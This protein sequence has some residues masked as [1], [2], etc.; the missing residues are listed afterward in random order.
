MD[1]LKY[2]FDKQLSWNFSLTAFIICRL[3][4][5]ITYFGK[6]YD[7][8][9]IFMGLQRPLALKCSRATYTGNKIKP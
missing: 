8:L 5:I 9:F 3:L 7:L 4:Q 1:F 2:L 6:D